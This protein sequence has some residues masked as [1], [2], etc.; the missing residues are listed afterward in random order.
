MAALEA[1]R[2]DM[3]KKLVG[4]MSQNYFCVWRV[5]ILE[6]VDWGFAP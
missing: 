2:D 1:F 5:L 6:K 4:S 3:V